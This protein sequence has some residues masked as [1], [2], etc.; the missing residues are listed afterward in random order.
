M[1]AA[2]RKL[3]CDFEGYCAHAYICPAGR[4]TIGYGH[5][6]RDVQMGTTIT[7]AAAEE[8]LD[9]DIADVEAI[10]RALVKVPLN[11]NQLAALICFAFNVGTG[12]LRNS[13]LLKKVNAHDFDGAALEFS[14]WNKGGGKELAGLTRRRAA[15]H[16]LFV[17][18]EVEC[19]AV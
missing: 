4:A 19:G 15:E 6:G 5:A 2:G 16:D 9:H 13:T 12:N 17:K 18:P 14:R 1:N 3:I 10:V 8:L 7:L 11:E